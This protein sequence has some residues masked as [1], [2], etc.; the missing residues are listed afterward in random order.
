MFVPLEDVVYKHIGPKIVAYEYPIYLSACAE[1]VCMCTK[2]VYV[3]PALVEP[4]FTI[5]KVSV[6]G[7]YS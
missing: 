3:T 2:I 5:K 6:D 1:K 7:N 4:S